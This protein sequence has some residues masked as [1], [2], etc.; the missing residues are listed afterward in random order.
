MRTNKT[1][2][3]FIQDCQKRIEIR[4]EIQQFYKEVYLPTVKKFDGKVY[5][6]RFI[7]ALREQITNPLMYISEL[8]GNDTIEIK[9]RLTQWNYTDVEW[10]CCKLVTNNE[11]RIDYNATINDKAGNKWQENFADGIEEYQ[12]TIDNYDSYMK[13]ADELET[14]IDKYNKLPFAFRGNINKAWLNIY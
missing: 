14:T 10:C 11:W 9:I 6:I 5:N 4:K 3:E 2:E 7:K 1:K 13:V 8:E 12:N